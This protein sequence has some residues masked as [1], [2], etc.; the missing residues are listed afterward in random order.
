M[1]DSLNG[2]KINNIIYFW[3]HTPKQQGVID[4]SCLS[5]W[6]PSIFHIDNM[7]YHNTEQYMMAEKAKLFEDFSTH[8]LILKE[9]NPKKVKSLGRKVKSFNAKI[10]D[11]EKLSIVIKGNYHKFN[12]NDKL[13]DYLL[14]TENNLLVEA[15]PY[16]NIWGIGIKKEK[17]FIHPFTWKGQNLLGF[18]LMTVREL[19]RQ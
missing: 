16:D 8:Q 14:S 10:W 4:K 13:K 15:S 17:D 11:Q 9:T 19:L 2:N 1:K 18:A 7:R 12:E 3:G 5:Q 6:F